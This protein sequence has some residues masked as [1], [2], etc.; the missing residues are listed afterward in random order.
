MNGMQRHY[1]SNTLNYEWTKFWRLGDEENKG[2]CDEEDEQKHRVGMVLMD[3]G[4][5]G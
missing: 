4:C 1:E 3:V 2:T 5:G